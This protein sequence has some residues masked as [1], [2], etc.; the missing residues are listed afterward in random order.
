MNNKNKLYE[1]LDFWFRDI[2]YFDFLER[3]LWLG[4]PPDYKKNVCHSFNWP[5]FIIWLPYVLEV[6]GNVCI[7]IICFPGCDV[8]KIEIKLSFHEQKSQNKNLIIFRTERAF[9]PLNVS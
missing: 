7:V 3:G 6:L 9:V 4:S 8:T 5:N 1:S 2:L